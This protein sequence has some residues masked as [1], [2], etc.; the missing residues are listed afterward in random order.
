VDEK[1]VVEHPL[2]YRKVIANWSD[3]WRERWGHRANSLEDLGLSWRDAET[4]A[5]IEVLHEIKE[6]ANSGRASSQS[7]GFANS[8]VDTEIRVTAFDPSTC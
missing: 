1:P 5:F 3:E 7:A 6:G 8:R 2:A 4:Q